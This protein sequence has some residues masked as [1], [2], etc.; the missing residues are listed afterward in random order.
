MRSSVFRMLILRFVVAVVSV[1]GFLN[2][3]VSAQAPDPGWP[4]QKTLNGSKLVYYQPQVDSWKDYKQLEFRMAFSVT[5]TGGK[6]SVGVATIDAAT[7]VDLDNRTVYLHG[8]TI[9]K[10]YFP[11]ADDDTTTNIGN[12]VKTFLPANTAITISLD[13]LVATVEKKKDVPNTPVSN[14]P[15]KI[16]VSNG[17][18]MLLFVDGEPVL[19]KIKDT[20]LQFVVN[21]NF[22]VFLDD[23]SKSYFLYTGKQWLSA[24]VLAGPWQATTTLPK[25]MSKIETDPQWAGLASAIPAPPAPGPAPTVFYSQV[26]AEVIVFQGAPVYTPIKGTQLVF[27]SNTHSDLF[28]YSP[29]QTYYYLAAGRWFSA[30]SLQGPWTFATP[31]L[32]ADFKKIPPSSP[33]GKILASVPGTEQAEDAV[34]IAQIPTTAIIDPVSAAAQASV[35]YSGPPKFEPIAGTS[36]SYA[37]NTN[38]KVILVNNVYY[39]CLN[40]VWFNSTSA[41]GPWVTA[42]V[43]PSEIYTIPPSSPVYNVTYVTQTVTS[44][45][46]VQASYTSGYY[47]AFIVGATWGAIVACG[48]GYYYPPY[49]YYPA[50]GYPMYYPWAATYGVGA[51]YGYGAYGV[52]RGVY[53]PYGGAVGYA[54]YNPYTGTYA[55]GATAYGP[56]GSA[57][58][59]RAYNPYTGTYARGASV[60]TPYGTRSG[61]AAYNPYTGTAAVT[62]QGSSAYGQWGTSV[63]SRGNQ[64]VQTGYASNSQGTVAGA[65]STSGGAVVA[66]SGQYNSGGVA[67]TSSGDMYA[68]KDGNVYKNTGS[69]WSQA[70]GSGGWNSVDTPNSASQRASSTASQRAQMDGGTFN[71][72]NSAM[73]DRQRGSM[74]SQNF[75]RSQSFGGGG[76]R[77]GGGFGGG[78]FG[79]GRRR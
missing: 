54:G 67:R 78:G 27:A 35:T 76:G 64:A 3:A 51:Y 57:S 17:P 20:K 44:T 46:A 71:S 5:P 37:V 4:R 60:S 77:F 72:L 28:V 50:V 11:G 48:S 79:G 59:G 75:Q 39:L 10:V 25:D 15:P 21:A 68:A 24:R 62:R 18:S 63:V 70:N 31:N 13:R 12:L 1:L 2:V 7:D 65:R 74:Q 19:T 34:L 33:S 9:T 6:E 52:A 73:Q 49:L 42:T 8:A 56:Y 30:S 61:G 53:G 22:P 58:V 16:L 36:M 23:S 45:G 47:G 38:D 41:Q 26:P 55:R 40:G 32:P 43:I 69:G 14:T 29:T 66:G